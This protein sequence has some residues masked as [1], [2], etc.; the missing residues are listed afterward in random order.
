MAPSKKLD[1]GAATDGGLAANAPEGI[2]NKKKQTKTSSKP[3][4]NNSVKKHATLAVAQKDAKKKKA[5]KAK[6]EGTIA[7]D[8]A[9]NDIDDK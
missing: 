9:G 4:N 6:K 5:K 3:R 1:A 7:M 8:T 2:K